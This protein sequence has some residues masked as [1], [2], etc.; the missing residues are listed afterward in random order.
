[1][2]SYKSSHY[3]LLIPLPEGK[4]LLFNTRYGGLVFLDPESRA[5]FEKAAREGGFSP[6]AYPGG[7]ECLREAAKKG[8]VVESALDE[9]EDYRKKYQ[10]LSGRR[11]VSSQ[12]AIGLT[13]AVSNACNMACPYCYEFTKGKAV[14]GEELVPSLEAFLESVVR[15]SPGVKAWTGLSVTW[16]GG[17]PLLGKRA[18]TELTPR[19]QDFCGRHGMKYRAAIVTNGLLLTPGNWALLRENG[20]DE[21]QVTLDGPRDLHESHRPLKAAAGRNYDRILENLAVMPEGMKLTVR[22]NVDKAVAGRAGEL[23]DDLLAYGIWPG[24]GAAVEIDF[25]RLRIY[26]KRDGNGAVDGIPAEDWPSCHFELRKLKADRYDRWAA[27]NGARPGKMVFLTERPSLADCTTMV[28]PYSFVVDA[29][30]YVSKCWEYVQ[31]EKAR[32]QHISQGYIPDLYRSW[33]AYSRVSALG[34]ECARCKYLP[35]CRS[36]RCIERLCHT[37]P[38]RTGEIE[39]GLKIQYLYYRDHPDR[40]VFREPKRERKV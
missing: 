1:M 21:V 9:P 32:I 34:G 2:E 12:A 40:M 26:E 14:F 25:V 37:C 35:A 11:L 22:V 23:L 13:L 39:N 19:L 6:E 31:E 15:L 38:A 17:E 18:I 8:Y 27:A 24:R 29:E 5:F 30:G 20:V 36:A 4:G 3:N 16:Y 10:G 28:S 33:S 7:K